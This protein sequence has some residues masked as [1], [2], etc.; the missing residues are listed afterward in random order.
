MLGMMWRKKNIPPLL[1]ALQA[2]M[3]TLEVILVIPQKIGHRFTWGP[4]YITPGHT[5][6]GCSNIQGHMLY[7][8]H[9]SLIYSSQKL[10]RTHM[11]LNRGMDTENVVQLH[12]GILLNY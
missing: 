2:G 9:G 10:E 11:S 6:R 5:P 4:S 3:T 7:Y 1:V 12:N 8:I